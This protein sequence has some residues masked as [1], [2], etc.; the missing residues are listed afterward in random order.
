MEWKTPS[1]NK[2]IN[3]QLGKYIYGLSRNGREK[4]ALYL[5]LKKLKEEEDE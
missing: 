5:I 3:R 2:Y 4:G 1:I